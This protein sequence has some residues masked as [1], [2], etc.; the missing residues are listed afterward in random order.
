MNEL[1]GI[2]EDYPHTIEGWVNFMH[3]DFMQPMNDAVMESIRSRKPFDEEYK[4]IRPGDGTKC[5]MH[6]LGQ[7]AYDDTG[8][9]VSLVGTVQDITEKKRQRDELAIY[10]EHLEHL[11]A[12]RTAELTAAEA[13]IRLI[14]ESSADGLMQVDNTW[15]IAM[16]NPAACEMLG[17]SPEQLL[18]RDMHASIHCSHDNAATSPDTCSLGVAMRAGRALRENME[19]FWCADG[20]PLSV[21]VAIHP[22]H[23]GETLIGAVLSFSDNSQRQAVEHA[24]EAA[25]AEA[26]LLARS[27][28]EFLANMSHEI[29]TPLNGV[30]GMAQIGYLDSLGR[31]KTQETFAHILE[32]GNLLLVIINDILDLSKIE[33]GKLV[34]ESIPVDPRHSVDA[35]V[36][37]LAQRAAE[38]GLTLLAEKAPDLPAA[39]VSD[40]TRIAQIL[41][42]LLSNAIKFTA[43]GEVH[44]AALRAEG[45][46]VF[47]ITDTGIGMTPGQVEALFTPFQQ[48]DSSTTRK[49]GGTGLGLTISRQLARLMGGEIHASST[50]GSGSTFELRLPC[51]E[52]MEAVKT[53]GVFTV[54]HA[55]L[56][57]KGLSILAAEDNEVNQIVLGD[58]LTREGVELEMVGNGRLAVEAV[59]RD[60]ARFDL[61]LMDAQMPEMDGFEA[62]RQI[63]IL[64][65]ALPVVGQTAHVLAAEHEKCRA[66][67][68][69][70]TITKPLD[71][72]V[73]VGV[74]LRHARRA[75]EITRPFHS[76]PPPAAEASIQVGMVD[77]IQLEQRYADRPAF[78][79]KLLGV[80]LTAHAEAPARI[81]AAAAS[82]DMDQL[83]FLAHTAKG[84]GGT[85]FALKLQAQAQV[86][87]ATARASGPDAIAHGE[88]LAAAF[89]A[90]LTEI[91]EYLA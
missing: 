24:R 55:E 72:G 47:R 60:P 84:T 50:A 91:R 19:T 66:A 53:T 13:H 62:T 79:P 51:I 73:L 9:A 10:R 43:H 30:L 27:K 28:S 83:A 34:V 68:M 75:T 58:M 17:Y 45:Q 11:V 8:R 40:P 90:T 1:F 87:V 18:G 49:Y 54:A 52:T 23:Q 76:Q 48:A 16:I 31:E 2:T 25:R 29:R 57:L 38:K 7:I 36:A 86:T 20:R 3:P 37:S 85:V 22:M 46:L 64:A 42:N 77:W 67:G 56:R 12:E 5:W 78:I 63:R 39:V 89:D 81:R 35:A 88:H 6:G 21:T 71:F 4:I 44:L 41:L 32:S 14:I 80:M 69:V 59:T 26:E 82:G 70:E 15:R 61:V 33:A 74:I 65:P